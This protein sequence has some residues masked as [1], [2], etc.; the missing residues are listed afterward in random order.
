M[1][2]NIMST[3]WILLLSLYNSM[4][5]ADVSSIEANGLEWKAGWSPA[6]TELT[7]NLMIEGRRKLQS[8]M[9][10]GY[11]QSNCSIAK[12]A[13]RKNWYSLKARLKI[14][15]A[16]IYCRIKMPPHERQDYTVAV[17]CLM[18]LP[19]R[20]SKTSPELAPGAKSRYKKSL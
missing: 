10:V 17:N 4:V 3:A 18:N 13:Q 6:T 16:N 14:P 2:S 1:K 19:S 5:T 12:A 8:F 15:R 7:D 11:I 20:L 9:G